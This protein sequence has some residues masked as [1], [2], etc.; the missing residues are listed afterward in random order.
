MR[1]PFPSLPFRV[2]LALALAGGP[3]WGT[4]AAAAQEGAPVSAEEP[5]VQELRTLLER[6]PRA[7]FSPHSAEVALASMSGGLDPRQRPTALFALGAAGERAMRPRLESWA[8][9]GSPAD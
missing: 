6:D 2:L 4:A 5:R 1:R 3:P 9:E 8:V 7:S